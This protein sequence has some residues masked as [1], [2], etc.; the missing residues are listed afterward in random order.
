VS[1]TTVVVCS[2]SMDSSCCS[3]IISIESIVVG[4]SS[5]PTAAAP[6]AVDE[7]GKVRCISFVR[8]F[9][10][11]F[12]CLFVCLFRS[13]KP[14]NEAV[15]RFVSHPVVRVWTQPILGYEKSQ[16]ELVCHIL[17]RKIHGARVSTAHK[18]KLD[19]QL[20]AAALP[21]HIRSDINEKSKNK[22]YNNETLTWS[23]LHQMQ[24]QSFL[25]I[26]PQSYWYQG[27]R[28]GALLLHRPHHL[29]QHPSDGSCAPV[30]AILMLSAVIEIAEP[31]WETLI[32]ISAPQC[33]SC[34]VLVWQTF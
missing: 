11:L 17:Q 26:V 28:E 31:D 13:I 8:L 9:V 6:S 5:S 20:L 29:Q 25:N 16:Y 14:V 2:R 1:S 19:I 18:P 23:H 3:R 12:V 10:R 30:T 4:T 22:R 15:S 32:L 27:A 24:S 33:E 7:G 34:F 21:P